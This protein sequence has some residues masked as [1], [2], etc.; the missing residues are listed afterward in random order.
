MQNTG[1]LKHENGSYK[2]IGEFKSGL[3][4]KNGI[5]LN[6]N[7]KPFFR[8]EFLNGKK[9]GRGKDNFFNFNKECFMTDKENR[10]FTK[11][12]GLTIKKMVSDSYT[13]NLF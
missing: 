13:I 10:L 4:S 8:G 11:E 6:S 5:C 2:Y 9:N 7:G 3:Y 12:I 1:I